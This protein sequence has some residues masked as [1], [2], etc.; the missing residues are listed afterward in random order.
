METENGVKTVSSPPEYTNNGGNTGGQAPPPSYDSLY[1]KLKEAKENSE[2]NTQFAKSAV[3]ICCASLVT[4]LMTL[5]WC[6]KAIACIVIGAIYLND[7]PIDQ[8]IPKYLIVYGSVFCVKTCLTSV[9]YWKTKKPTNDGQEQGQCQGQDKCQESPAM[10]ALRGIEGCLDS[11]LFIWFICGNVFVYRQH[12]KYQS[13]DPTLDNYCHKTCYLFAFWVITVT[14]IFIGAMLF[15]S[16]CCCCFICCFGA[17]KASE[18]AQGNNS[19]GNAG[20]PQY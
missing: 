12:G 2:D 13:D 5:G 11:F 1:G 19:N 9:K 17:K 3:S 8:N 16:C 20:E 18:H 4:V 6:A 7:C 10:R 15:F 14:Y